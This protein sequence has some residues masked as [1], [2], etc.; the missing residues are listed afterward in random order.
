MGLREMVSEWI[1]VLKDTFDFGPAFPAAM[2][3]QRLRSTQELTQLQHL[4][5]EAQ[6]ASREKD[7]LIAKLQAAT[8]ISGDVAVDGSAC[9]IETKENILDGPYPSKAASIQ[10][11]I[12]AS[13][14]ENDQAGSPGTRR[15]PH[16]QSRHQRSKGMPR[17][18]R[19]SQDGA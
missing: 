5:E 16:S 7:K 1:K 4:L 9:C 14:E 15:K 10:T 6:E 3:G 17:T 13:P 19:T 2:A 12:P 18:A 11:L 8:A